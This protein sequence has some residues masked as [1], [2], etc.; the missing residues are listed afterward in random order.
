[1]DLNGDIIDNDTGIKHNIDAEAIFKNLKKSGKYI[2][3]VFIDG[4]KKLNQLCVAVP[5]Y[6]KRW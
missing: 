5:V 6:N 1:M 3:D 4:N 2:S